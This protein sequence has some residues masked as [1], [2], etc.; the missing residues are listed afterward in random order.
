[1]AEKKKAREKLVIEVD[2]K[3]YIGY[4]E[5]RGLRKPHQ[6]VSFRNSTIDDNWTYDSWKFKD[7]KKVMNNKA[8]IL[9]RKL[10]RQHLNKQAE[11]G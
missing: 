6:R 1:L 10:V 11:S 3:K 7:P 9:L 8:K 4:R 5:I 2:G